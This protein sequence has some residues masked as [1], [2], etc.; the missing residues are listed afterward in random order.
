MRVEPCVLTILV[1][2]SAAVHGVEAGS[3]AGH[4]RRVSRLTEVRRLLPDSAKVAAELPP[5]LVG[6][7]P[8]AGTERAT[9]PLRRLPRVQPAV[10]AA[11]LLRV[12]IAVGTVG[13]HV[14]VLGHPQ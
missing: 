14:Q 13:A 7:Q 4:E 10:L 6:G 12:V 9:R 1:G 8:P 3:A 5:L 2:A 11:I